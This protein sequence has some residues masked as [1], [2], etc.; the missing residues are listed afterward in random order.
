MYNNWN[1]LY[2]IYVY[3]IYTECIQRN[4]GLEDEGKW[5]MVL[6]KIREGSVSVEGCK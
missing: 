4:E 1:V 2:I 5:R 6:Q 3:F